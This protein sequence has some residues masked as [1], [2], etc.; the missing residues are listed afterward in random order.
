MPSSANPAFLKESLAKNECIELFAF[1]G[2]DGLVAATSLDHIR[3][4]DIGHRDYYRGAIEGDTYISR[5]YISSATYNFCV[6]VA[7]PVK[8]MSGG[9]EGVLLTDVDITKPVTSY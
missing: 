2:K 5:P 7:M 8:N 6:S 4:L 1:A 3:G 9:I